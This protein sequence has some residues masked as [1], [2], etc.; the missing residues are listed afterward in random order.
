[1][2]WSSLTLRALGS[3]PLASSACFKLRKKG[4][5]WMFHFV[6]L[7]AIVTTHLRP[8]ELKKVN[9]CAFPFFYLQ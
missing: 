5:F 4:K 8:K 7:C 1:M 2:R 3:P 9:I 6:Q